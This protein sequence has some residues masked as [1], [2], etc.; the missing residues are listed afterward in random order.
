ML[1]HGLTLLI[2]IIVLLL[3]VGVIDE[4]RDYY[5]YYKG[6][7]RFR[8]MARDAA[9]PMVGWLAVGATVWLVGSFII[10]GVARATAPFHPTTTHTQDLVAL[11]SRDT[12]QGEVR[13]SIFASYGYIEGARVLS[14]I[15]RQDDGGLKLGYVSA[16]D[17][18]VYEDVEVGQV[19]RLVTQHWE[20]S[21]PFLVD[22]VLGQTDTYSLHVPEGSVADT[23]EVAP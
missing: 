23:F 20:Q 14:Y 18:V 7:R 11:T 9:L 1:L 22:A 10:L 6:F 3:W 13:G 8:L 21:N 17:S 12:V 5:N 4:I 16:S 15:T 2:A 19:P